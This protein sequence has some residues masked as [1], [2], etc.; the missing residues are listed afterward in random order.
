MEKDEP[1]N[2]KESLKD[3]ES[4]E[5]EKK[6]GPYTKKEQEERKIQ[7]YHL[8]F[9]ENK[10]ALEI[11]ELLNVNRNTIND[12]IRYWHQQLANEFKAQD[13]TAKMTKQIQRMEI[14]RDRLLDDLDEAESFD[15]KIKLEKFVSDVDNRLGQ[16]FSKMISSGKTNLAPTVKLDEINDNEIKELV[17]DLVLVDDPYADDVFSENYLKH[18]L[19]EKTHCDVSY[20][21]NVIEKMNKGGL[22]ICRQV[23]HIEKNHILWPSF[24]NSL[25][26]N[27]AKF[28]TMRGYVSKEEYISFWTERQKMRSEIKKEEEVVEKFEQK[29]GPESEWSEQV[30]EMFE[31]SVEDYIKSSEE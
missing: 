7:V 29:Y 8:H 11:A 20:T 25:T 18:Y 31:K 6:G 4:L 21:E 14:Q 9:E 2:T 23:P 5:P 1:E 17:R 10:S 24:D 13:L 15:E 12:D 19:I 22:E 26:Y 27:L 16:L 3:S 28:G 30:K